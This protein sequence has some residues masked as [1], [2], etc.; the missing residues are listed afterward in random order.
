[1][2]KFPVTENGRQK[3]QEEL[4][5][6]KL[7]DRPRIIEAIKVARE[8]GDLKENAE[9]QEAKREQG[10]IEGRVLE[11]EGKLSNCQVIDVTQM[12]NTGR[13]IFGSTVTLMNTDTDEEVTYQI[14]GEDE[15]DIKI[16][17]ISVT[18]PISRA[19]VAKEEGD[20][21]DVVTPNGVVKYEIVEVKY[22]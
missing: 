12:E 10:M 22:I 11:L 21:V 3:M 2:Q 13:V 15:A 18:S 5:R 14:V 7:S 9:Y 20:S 19:V 16:N 8:L 17:K 1:M 4:D 6:L